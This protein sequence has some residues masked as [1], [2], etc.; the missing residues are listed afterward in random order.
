MRFL[1]DVQKPCRWASLIT[2]ALMREPGGFRLL[3]LLR[4][5]GKYIRIP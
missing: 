2:G 4:V 3:G 1:G 5:K